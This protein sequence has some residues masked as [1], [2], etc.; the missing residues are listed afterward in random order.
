MKLI[1]LINN[2]NIARN[3]YCAILGATCGMLS[4]ALALIIWLMIWPTAPYV[5]VNI[6]AVALLFWLFWDKLMA[7]VVDNTPRK[8]LCVDITLPAAYPAII[9]PATIAHLKST[10]SRIV[11]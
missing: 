11:D 9:T 4:H 3:I 2:N 1:A 10:A 6:T 7:H 8:G 5:L